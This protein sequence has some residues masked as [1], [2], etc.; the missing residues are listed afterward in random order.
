M[1]N[2]TGYEIAGKN[3]GCGTTYGYR[4][5]HILISPFTHPHTLIH[6]RGTE[7]TCSDIY[8]Y[9]ETQTDKG[10]K[11]N[12]QRNTRME[13]GR[14]DTLIVVE[15]DGDSKHITCGETYR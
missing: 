3:T 15:Q 8:A 4:R 9:K 14:E 13:K 11:K 7:H 1:E 5:V 6:S 2:R 12:T 10:K